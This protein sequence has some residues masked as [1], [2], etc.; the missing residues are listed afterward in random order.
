[1]STAE[2]RERVERAPSI[3]LGDLIEVATAAVSRATNAE[4]NPQPLPPRRII[5]GIIYEPQG[6]EAAVGASE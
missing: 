6:I 2:P 3:A 5:I 1:M 4:L